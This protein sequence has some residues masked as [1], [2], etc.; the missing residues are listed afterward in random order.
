MPG[1][2][3]NP[4]ASSASDGTTNANNL[5]GKAGEDIVAELHGKYY[6]Q[7]Y[8]GVMFGATQIAATAPAIFTATAVTGFVLWNPQGSGRNIIPVRHT[9]GIVTAAS[10]QVMLGYGLV[11]NAGSAVA[12]AA[13]F[14][15]LTALSSALINGGLLNGTGQTATIAKVGTGATLTNAPT[16]FVP[17][18]GWSTNAITAAQSGFI[19][20]FDGRLILQ[21]GSALIVSSSVA[22]TGT[23]LSG[24]FWY[25]APL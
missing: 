12:T 13:P 23:G 18:F 11:Q 22:N 9:Y 25:E 1:T 14:S 7:A 10:A 21:P 24:F 8:R 17:A 5:F 6:T 3:F 20:D 2:I 4:T 15:A 16:Q 19:D